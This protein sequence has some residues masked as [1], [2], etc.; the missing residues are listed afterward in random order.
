MNLCLVI[1]AKQI[2]YATAAF[3]LTWTHSVE[4]THW[5]EDWQVTARGLEIVEA[6]IEGSG[7]GMDP[8]PEAT[9]DG[10][11]WRYRPDLPPLPE[12]WLARS[13]ATGGDWQ[14]CFAGSC[15]LVP[16]PTGADNV[17]ALL[18]PCQ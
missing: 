11:Y 3:T 17:P 18:K 15:H 6:R 12:L 14:I 1:G 9:F 2:L 4:K 10:R 5:S 13:G 8:P 7:A 16:E